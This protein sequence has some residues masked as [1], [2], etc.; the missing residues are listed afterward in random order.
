MGRIVH[1]IPNTF[2]QI[3]IGDLGIFADTNHVDA[4][5]Q[6]SNA[7]NICLYCTFRRKA[8]H[9]AAQVDNSLASLNRDIF[10]KPIRKSFQLF[11]YNRNNRIIRR[12]L[13]ITRVAHKDNQAIIHFHDKFV[14]G[15]VFDDSNGN[16]KLFAD[17]VIDMIA[18]QS[19][20]ALGRQKPITF[21]RHLMLYRNFRAFIFFVGQTISFVNNNIL[22]S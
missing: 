13:R 17:N 4:T 14:F 8:I 1:D 12:I 11:A 22:V 9:K 5:A 3:S 20:H 15:F 19:M 10:A 7:I 6:S 2:F 21:R 18:K 16:T